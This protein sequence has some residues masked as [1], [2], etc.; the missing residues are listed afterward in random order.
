MSEW[1][2]VTE[3][4]PE[5]L[6]T[7]LVTFTW[8]GGRYVTIDRYRYVSTFKNPIYWLNTS[9]YMGEKV[10]AWMPMPKPY[11]VKEE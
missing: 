9:Q 1:I 10:I 6:E 2:P 5:E 8:K 3:R 4:L 7:V 11:E